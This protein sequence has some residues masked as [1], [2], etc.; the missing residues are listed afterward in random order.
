MGA[1]SLFLDGPRC[2][3]GTATGVLHLALAHNER[4]RRSAADSLPGRAGS[5]GDL[6]QLAGDRVERAGHRLVQPLSGLY[7]SVEVNPATRV[8]GVVGHAVERAWLDAA[9][10]ALARGVVGDMYDE[11]PRL[12]DAGHLSVELSLSLGKRVPRLLIT[13]LQLLRRQLRDLSETPESEYEEA[14]VGV[15]P[16]A[17]VGEEAPFVLVQRAADPVAL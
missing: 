11:M 16:E 9:V 10:L 17:R 4:Q 8:L 3:D 1:L 5:N 6:A 13:A 14:L 7:R 12:R 15:S 2:L